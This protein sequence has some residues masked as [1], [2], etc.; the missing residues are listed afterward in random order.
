[1]NAT[2]QS[3]EIDIVSDVMC[4]WCY[5]GKRRL[6]KALSLRPDI[7]YDIRWRPFQLDPTIPPEGIDR[8][9]YLQKKFGDAAG[10]EMYDALKEAGK[11]EGIPFAF[12]DIEISPNT[13]NAHRLI[14]WGATA[15]VQNEIVEALFE[16]YFTKG[17]N[18]VDKAYLA[19][20]AEDAGM[21]KPIVERLLDGD[22]DVELVQEEI[23]LAQRM[24]VT[25]VP[26]FILGN[27]VVV[28]GAQD[29]EVLARAIDQALVEKA[30]HD[31]KQ[32]EAPVTH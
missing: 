19:D 18:L 31:D 13:I 28:M 6:E 30:K 22:A 26:C 5:V 7:Q 16:G 25:G 9:E 23:A 1:M 20:L 11:V 15:G 21:E 29:A 4:P 32:E 27:R 12:K 3:L 10:G 14:K 17:A 2:P 24:G 8:K